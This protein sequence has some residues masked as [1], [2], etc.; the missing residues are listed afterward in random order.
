MYYE[1]NQVNEILLCQYCQA[2]LEG[3]KLLPCGET[4]CSFC[5]TSIQINSNIFDCLVC[6]QKHEMPKNGLPDNKVALKM[7]SVQPNRVSRGQAVDLFEKKLDEI[8]KKYKLIKHSIENS[9]DLVKEHCIDLR[10]DVQ[11]KTE[12]AIQQINDISSKIIEEI[13]EYEI[14]LIGF[15]KTNSKSLDEFD[16]IA[17]ELISFHA[18][19]IE[20]L[21]NHKI[22]E[23]IVEKSIEEAT[24]LIKKSELEIQKLKD[25]IF[26]GKIF[27]FEKNSAKINKSI[28]GVATMTKNGMD[29]IILPE[30]NQI[31]HLIT[32]CDFQTTKRFNLIY[33]ASKDGFEASSFHLKCDKQPNTLIII[34]SEHGNIFGG[35]TEQDWTPNDDWKTDKNSFIFSLINKDNKSLKIKCPD[36]SKAISCHSNYGPLFGYGPA[37]QIS[38][39][40]NNR[41]NFSFLGITSCI[42]KHPYYPDNS[43]EAE[44]F[45]AGSKKF[46]VLEI[47]A[48]FLE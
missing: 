14:E 1:T 11:L 2:Q 47:E 30:T 16:S 7:L 48:Y 44:S 34:K 12:E 8:L 13:D 6:H 41:E 5:V 15:N 18:V 33:R 9:T 26:D 20:Y 46:K 29:S 21:R 45:L 22:D 40:S 38:N 23:Q 3:P 28:L 39:N 17:S 43:L 35:Y 31:N 27:I 19:N 24:N 36:A 25:I 4:I 37:F 32:L 10:S 42:Y